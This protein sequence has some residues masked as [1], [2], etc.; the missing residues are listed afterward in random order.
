MPILGRH[1][2]TVLT[3]AVATV[4]TPVPPARAQE[5]AL[6]AASQS[7]HALFDP[8]RPLIGQTWR[9]TGNNNPDLTDIMRW[10]WAVGGH[11]VHVSHAVNGGIYGGETLIFPDRD[12]GRLIFHYFT[13]GGFHTTGTIQAQADGTLIIDE[14]VHGL[15]SIEQQRSRGQFLADG[16]YQTQGLRLVDGAWQAFGGF[17]YHPDPTAQVVLTVPVPKAVEATPPPPPREAPAVAGALDLSRRLMA[18]PGQERGDVAAYLR[19]HNGDPVADR[20]LSVSCSCADR[21]EFH[22]IQRTGP[23]AG[24]ISDA[25]WD[26][27]GQGQ[28][29]IRPGSDLHLMLINFDPRSAVQGRVRLSLMFEQ[30]GAV[31]AD[32]FLA[33]DT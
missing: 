20:L 5:Q 26:I 10:D 22:R 25:T 32:F 18:D 8:I 9:G 12:S 29:D 21:V 19:V 30:N 23:G 33:P 6:P 15:D 17:T 16:G 31:D 11:A 13:T 14:T 24:M 2:L 7:G 27:P 1:V 28:L 3:V 4:V